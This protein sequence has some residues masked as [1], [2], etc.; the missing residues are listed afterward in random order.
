MKRDRGQLH[1]VQGEVVGLE[2]EPSEP[3]DSRLVEL[4]RVLSRVQR[5][6]TKGIP[7][8]QERHLSRGDLGAEHVSA[9]EGATIAGESRTLSGHELMFA[10]DE[11][12]MNVT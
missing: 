7:Q 6:Q 1:V 9:L 3:A 2:C 11:Q 10:R 12:A 8:R 4:R 5:E